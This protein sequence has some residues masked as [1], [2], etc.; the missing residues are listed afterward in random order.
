[1]RYFILLGLILAGCST[2]DVNQSSRI[3]ETRY[4]NG[5][6][7]VE[8]EVVNKISGVGEAKQVID[9]L[10][11]SQT[12]SGTITVGAEG[13]DSEATS[14]ALME[15]VSSLKLLLELGK[16]MATTPH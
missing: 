16:A 2:V 10:R 8:R 13:V 12:K 4:T 14:P 11:A 9:K 5:V 7:V 15:L 3:T 6:V 1:M